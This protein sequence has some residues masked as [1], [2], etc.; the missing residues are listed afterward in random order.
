MPLRFLHVAFRLLL[1][2][3]DRC[4]SWRSLR[5]RSPEVS[6]QVTEVG[7]RR[8]L[9]DP[10]TVRVQFCR[11]TTWHLDGSGTELRLVPCKK[12]HHHT[13]F[14]WQ[15]KSLPGVYQDTPHQVWYPRRRK[16]Q[17]NHALITHTTKKSPVDLLPCS[18]EG[19]DFQEPGSHN[20]GGSQCR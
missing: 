15:A 13:D 1:V 5:G 10:H 2:F 4:H 14:G 7:T 19:V 16:D 3:V 9:F 6:S 18:C 12:V 8:H 11:G 17:S 20:S